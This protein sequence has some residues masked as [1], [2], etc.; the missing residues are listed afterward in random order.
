[1]AIMSFFDILFEG[2]DYQKCIGDANAQL[3]NKQVNS[4]VIKQGRKNLV[5]SLYI[6]RFDDASVGG[7]TNDN[8]F[9]VVSNESGYHLYNEFG[10]EGIVVR[11][12]KTNKYYNIGK[13]ESYRLQNGDEIYFEINASKGIPIECGNKKYTFIR[14]ARFTERTA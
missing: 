4:Y 7:R 11:Q 6:L 13:G 8:Y 14:M 3:S 10:K 2:Q 5:K 1:M 12:A 9:T